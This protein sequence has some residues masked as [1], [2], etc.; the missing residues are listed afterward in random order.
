MSA[1]FENGQCWP[2]LR[3][4]LKRREVGISIVQVLGFRVRYM[5][6]LI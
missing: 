6:P 1:P 2:R 5:Q 3:G 4:L